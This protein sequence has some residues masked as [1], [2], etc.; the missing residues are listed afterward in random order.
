MR[1]SAMTGDEPVKMRCLSFWF[2]AFGRGDNSVLSVY[3][4]KLEETEGS[5]DSG[6]GGSGGGSSGDSLS[7][8]TGSDG[9]KVSSDGRLLLWSIQSRFLETRRNLWY[10]AQTAVN[11]ET[12]YQVSFSYTKVYPKLMKL[13]V[14]LSQSDPFSR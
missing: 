14:H 6:T 8:A 1:F 9:E 13:F 10:Y 12:E 3:A 11:A 5:S 7:T 2:S 4:M